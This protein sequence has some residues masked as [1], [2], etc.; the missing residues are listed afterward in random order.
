M[1]TA[2]DSISA[3]SVP[4]APVV[5]G[6]DDGHWP[7]AAALGAKYPGATVVRI[8]VDPA[9]NLGDMLDVERGDATPAD[10][11]GWVTRRRAAGHG[12][13]LV[14][15]AESNRA[16][17]L[18]AF[19]DAGVPLPGRFVAAMPGVGAALQQPG[20][21]GHQYGQGGGGAYDISVVVD[22][23]AGIDPP[24]V[25]PGPAP[26]TATSSPRGPMM[27]H[28]VSFTTDSQGNGAVI[29]DGGAG[30]VPGITSAPGPVVP[31]ST[32]QA[33][34]MQGSD[35]AADGGYWPGTVKV[36]NRGGNVLVSVVGFLPRSVAIVFVLATE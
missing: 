36:Q 4:W 12:G 8:T 1:R 6:Y 18:A 3:A 15:F 33:A 21:V 17:V 2:Y 7:D 26:P 31:W 29:L 30:S 19:R 20:D 35:P 25:V 16:A 28:A 22:Y 34:T 23:L 13:P 32:F 9:D 27:L 11:P 14:Y 24:A 5:M 10:A